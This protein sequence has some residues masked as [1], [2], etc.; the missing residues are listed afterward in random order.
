MIWNEW[1]MTEILPSDVT[2]G[3]P[4]ISSTHNSVA[5]VR[6]RERVTSTC[7][8]DDRDDEHNDDR[9]DYDDDYGDYDDDYDGDYNDYVDYDEVGSHSGRI[10]GD[11]IITMDTDRYSSDSKSTHRTIDMSHT[12]ESH[13]GSYSAKYGDLLTLI[14]IA[15][16]FLTIIFLVTLLILTLD[17]FYMSVV[18]FVFYFRCRIHQFCL[19]IWTLGW[20]QR[21]WKASTTFYFRTTRQKG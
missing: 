14:C 21:I 15:G 20:R 19:T 11:T 4:T 1:D 3:Q 8:R 12:F 10:I 5:G 13:S 6:E 16:L 9:D 7:Y 18:V 2:R 17:W